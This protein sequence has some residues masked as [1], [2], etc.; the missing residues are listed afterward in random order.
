[1]SGRHETNDI[2]MFAN[3][4][5]EFIKHYFMFYNDMN[6]KIKKF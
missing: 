3:V 6:N 1:M 2:I 4:D 5:A